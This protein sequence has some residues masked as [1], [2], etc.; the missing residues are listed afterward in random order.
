MSLK[1]WPSYVQNTSYVQCTLK[2]LHNDNNEN[3]KKTKI[4]RTH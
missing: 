4:K 3:G 2:Y 1:Q